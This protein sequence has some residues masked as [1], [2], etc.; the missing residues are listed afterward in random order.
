MKK[1]KKWTDIKVEARKAESHR[2]SV[3]TPQSFDKEL[4][5]VIRESLLSG[6]ALEPEVD[7]KSA[8]CAG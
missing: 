1:K 6:A 7:T 4:P 2:Q 5:G 8:G 3:G